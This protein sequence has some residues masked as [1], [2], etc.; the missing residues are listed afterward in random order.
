[1]KKWIVLLAALMLALASPG[2]AASVSAPLPLDSW[3][4][5][6]LDKL[7][8][9]GLIDSSLK[10]SRPYTR[11][12]AA[13]LTAAARRSHSASRLPV[14]AELL[15][16]LERELG[17]ELDELGGRVG[18]DYF[19][20][21]RGASLTHAWR[22]GGDSTTANRTNATQFALD[23]NR[24][25]L[26]FSEG[27]NAQLIFESEARLWRRLHFSAR[28][29]FAIQEEGTDGNWRL[30][31][32]RAA[33]GLGP[34]ELSFGRQSL[35]WGQGRN[36]TLVL[37]NNAKPLDMLRITNPSPVL[38]PWVF[39][40]LGPL[41]FDMFWSE[42]ESAR[43]VPNPYFAGM[44]LNF[45]PLPWLEIGGSRA[46]MFGGEG[47]PG[48]DL[49]E[50][51]TILVGKNLE[52]GEDTSNQ[53]AALD[54]RLT[55]PFLG[56]AELYGELGGE[57]EAGGFIAKKA[58]L[59][60]VYLPQLE[61]SGRLAL[62]VEHTNLA[63]EGHGPVWYRH[64]QYR[65]GYTYERKILGHHLGGDSRS[66]YGELSAYLPGGLSAALDLD[67]QTRGYSDPIRESHLQPG[68]SL[69]WQATDSLRLSGRYAFDRVRNRGN[70][71]GQNETHHFSLLTLDYRL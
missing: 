25:G 23:T 46:V 56:N 37:S 44:R 16:D 43:E 68:L 51:V 41:R 48:I 1:M 49:S 60:G 13:R 38:L 67:Y 42:L 59:A 5:P 70:L 28:P 19:Q 61:P 65:S 3:V 8:G 45:K 15:R 69:A 6:A 12:E 40:Y 9:L 27:H 47:R 33:L 63:Y 20:P 54:A 31:D 2:F 24:Q 30:L 17:S 26:N 11:L 7:E 18:V 55:L 71:S 52:G 64:S 35:W 66:W 29:L 34:V 53:L 50:F 62:R 36:G 10:G 32:G 58:W 22:D 39:K 57:D 14:A 21:L 4:Y